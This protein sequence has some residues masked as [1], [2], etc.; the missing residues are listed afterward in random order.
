MRG[1]CEGKE[2]EENS[3]D[4]VKKQKEPSNKLT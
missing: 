1:Y 4:I 3:S 2:E